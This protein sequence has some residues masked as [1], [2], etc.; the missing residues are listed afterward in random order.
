MYL[1]ILL[2]Y[3]QLLIFIKIMAAMYNAPWGDSETLIFRL[4]ST[5][6]QYS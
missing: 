1:I 3:T 2:W 4:Y 6:V 5:V